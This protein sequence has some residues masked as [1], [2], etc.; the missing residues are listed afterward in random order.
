MIAQTEA[1]NDIQ[2]TDDGERVISGAT[3]AAI[4]LVADG[5]C[6]DA[7]SL[8]GGQTQLSTTAVASPARVVGRHWRQEYNRIRYQTV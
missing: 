7:T 2:L 1:S 3:G 5:A 4:M 6:A 8:G